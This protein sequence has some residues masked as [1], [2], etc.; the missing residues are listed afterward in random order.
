MNAM[1]HLSN[2]QLSGL[3]DSALEPA[4]ELATRAHLASCDS[5]T[6][7]LEALTRLGIALQAE[8]IP[9]A[10]P[11]LRARIRQR[12]DKRRGIPRWSLGVAAVIV[13]GAMIA[14]LFRDQKLAP[15]TDSVTSE[16]A[17]NAIDQDTEEQKDALRSLGY[18]GNAPV[19]DEPY[20]VEM[21][22]PR[23]EQRDQ[24]LSGPSAAVK[25]ESP[26]ASGA[27]LPPIADAQEVMA[28]SDVRQESRDNSAAPLAAVPS[29]PQ[30]SEK[31][32][33]AGASSSADESAPPACVDFAPALTLRFEIAHSSEFLGEFWRITGVRPRVE[34]ATDDGDLMLSVPRQAWEQYR[35]SSGKASLPV[36][37]EL[38]ACVRFRLVT[39]PRH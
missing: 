28:E 34:S 18:V 27:A 6:G 14:V 10:P 15:A 8:A 3:L 22:Q 25:A 1:V 36:T 4:E 38:A 37:P 30:A 39:S 12:L 32:Q 16:A 17:S 5:C 20:P 23:K 31:R 35:V 33:R 19:S 24:K 21:S 29:A 13:A 11:E 2:E 7:K 26:A 9:P